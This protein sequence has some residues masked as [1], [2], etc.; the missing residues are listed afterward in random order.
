MYSSSCLLACID[1]I[2]VADAKAKGKEY[3]SK[4][5]KLGSDAESRLAQLKSEAG[6][7]F[8]E[9]RKDTNKTIDDLDK[10]VERKASEAKS[11]ISSWF[12]GSK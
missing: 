5:G 10:T 7:K 8:D 3:D 9:V 11:G 2:Q 12:G 1:T 6:G 4:I